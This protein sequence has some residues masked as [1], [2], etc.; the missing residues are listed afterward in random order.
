MNT[1]KCVWHE[2][3]PRLSSYAWMWVC[4]S[5]VTVVGFIMLKENNKVMFWQKFSSIIVEI[6]FLLI[7]CLCIPAVTSELSTDMSE[8]PPKLCPVTVVSML[9]ISVIRPY[10]YSRI[11][12]LPLFFL[13]RATT[14]TKTVP[15]PTWTEV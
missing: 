13:V 14:K 1:K 5:V 6:I 9:W 4:F 2:G 3:P 7:K 8:T 10:F 11:S 15:K 12:N